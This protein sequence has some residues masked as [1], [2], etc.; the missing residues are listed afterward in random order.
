M[1]MLLTRVLGNMPG[2]TLFGM[3]L[4]HA[5]VLWNRDQTRRYCIQYDT[6]TMALY[7]FA[8]SECAGVRARE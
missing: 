2:A 6:Q 5:C 1:Y 3:L 4:D 8:L 7:I